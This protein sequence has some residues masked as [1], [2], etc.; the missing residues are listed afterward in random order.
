MALLV[1]CTLGFQAQAVPVTAF[2]PTHFTR[3]NGTPVTERRT[4]HTLHLNGSFVLTVYNGGLED[5]TAQGELVSSSTVTLNGVTVI[6]PQNFDQ[7]ATVV[8]VPVT[9][10]SANELTVELRGKP[11]GVI[12]VEITGTVNNAPFADAGI[13]QTVNVGDTVTL[14]GTASTDEDGDALTYQWTLVAKPDGSQAALN[15]S[16]AASPSFVADEPGHY[17]AGLVVNDG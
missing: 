9:L 7:D 15:P 8:T 1:L 16:N 5:D 12:T 17:V 13:N 2:E 6:G 14:N 11:G 3:Q 4:F 10:T